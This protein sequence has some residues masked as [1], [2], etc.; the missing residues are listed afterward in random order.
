MRHFSIVSDRA[1]GAEGSKSF[2]VHSLTIL[3]AE[4]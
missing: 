4:A 1:P 3:D 2:W